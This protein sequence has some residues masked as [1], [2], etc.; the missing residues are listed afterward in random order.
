M[1]P[2]LQSRSGPMLLHAYQVCAFRDF[3]T[4]SLRSPTHTRSAPKYTQ[5]QELALP[6]RYPHPDQERLAHQNRLTRIQRP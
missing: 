1:N 4:L 5:G 3:R 6:T 2:I